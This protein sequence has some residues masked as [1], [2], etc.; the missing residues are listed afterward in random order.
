AKA[1][2]SQLSYGPRDGE[3]SLRFSGV[4]FNAEP[5]GA[6]DSRGSGAPGGP[7]QTVQYTLAMRL[8]DR[9]VV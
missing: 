4:F 5:R 7:R 3:M 9:E 2:L 6:V 8:L 1:A